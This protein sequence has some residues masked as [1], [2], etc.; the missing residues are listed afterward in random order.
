ME[1]F[2]HL[3]NLALFRRRLA[4][5]HDDTERQVLLTLLAD[6]EAKDLSPKDLP[7]KDLPQS[8]DLRQEKGN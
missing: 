3:E 8:D 2:I 7:P 1:R 4:E 5:P 6:E